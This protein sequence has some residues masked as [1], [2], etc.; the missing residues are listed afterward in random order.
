MMQDNTQWRVS[1]LSETVKNSFLQTYIRIRERANATC[2]L[3]IVI[4][5]VIFSFTRKI[6]D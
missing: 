6:K 1:D 2:L 5:C 3:F 4:Y